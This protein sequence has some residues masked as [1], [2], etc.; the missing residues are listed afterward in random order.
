[1]RAVVLAVLSALVLAP[2]AA[3]AF[4]GG[5]DCSDIPRFPS[6][7]RGDGQGRSNRLTLATFDARWIATM[8]PVNATAKGEKQDKAVADRLRAEDRERYRAFG[9]L[10]AE[11]KADVVDVSGT[12]GCGALRQMLSA[13]VQL[14]P[15]HASKVRQYLHERPEDKGIAMRHTGMLTYVDPSANITRVDDARVAYP[16]PHTRCPADERDRADHHHR[17]NRNIP[18][19]PPPPTTTTTRPRAPRTPRARAPRPAPRVTG[20][21]KDHYVTRMAV[22]NKNVT[23]LVVHFDEDDWSCAR[24]E[25]AATIVANE[26]ARTRRGGLGFGGESPGRPRTTT[27][28]T[29]GGEA[30]PG[31]RRRRSTAG[32]G[33]TTSWSSPGFPRRARAPKIPRRRTR[34]TRTSWRTRWRSGAPSSSCTSRAAFSDCRRADAVGAEALDRPRRNR[35]S[36]VF[37]SKT[38]V[39]WTTSVTAREVPT[40]GSEKKGLGHP[41]VVDITFKAYCAFSGDVDTWEEFLTPGVAFFAVF[42]LACF[43]VW[44]LGI[45]RLF[46]GKDEG[47]HWMKNFYRWQMDVP[48]LEEFL[49]EEERLNELEEREEAEAEA[50]ERAAAEGGGKGAGETAAEDRDEDRLLVTNVA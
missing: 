27:K 44:S 10:L 14:L 50:R 17:A 30:S 21:P 23:L 6:D 42:E 4:R 35:T 43:C 20:P 29:T 45:Y 2:P 25:A 26:A 13:E 49:A 7:R 28:T 24:R 19:P 8:S 38:L 22:G 46:L 18:A 37:L 41:L 31:R 16:I 36:A 39:E 40:P 33:W 11:I 32:R 1:M 3:D 15:E 12:N 9:K 47:P 5:G 34:R 48:T